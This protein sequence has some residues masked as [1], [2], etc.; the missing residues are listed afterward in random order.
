MKKENIPFTIAFLLLSNTL[1]AQLPEI[2][3]KPIAEIFTDF[4][5]NLNDTSKTTGFGLN[6]AYFGYNFIPSSDF[7]ATIILNI[8]NPEDLPISSV[9]RRYAYVR[10]ASVAYSGDRL[11]ISFGITGTRHFNY[12]QKFWGKRYIANTFQALNLF[13]VVADL[14][15]VAD[16]K[17]S[18]LISA[19]VTVMN[20]EGYSELQLDNG[21][22][23]SA[24]LTVTPSTKVAIR[25]YNDI[26]R[27]NGVWQYTL[28]TFAGFRNDHITIGAEFNYKTNLDLRAGDNAWGI[29][30][31]G[32]YSLPKKYEIFGRYDYS[33]SVALPED[34][35]HWNYLLDGNL[36]I[37]GI[38]RV[39]NQYFKMAISYQE[40]IPYDADL[41]SKSIIYLS[42]SF[43]F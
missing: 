36:V 23:T 41:N 12:Q 38:Q 26:N 1:L 31:T 9:H 6:R 10:E 11:H 35:N 25:F 18:D 39:F 21:V 40:T 5:I 2:K 19:D 28:L 13:G 7:S 8:G 27:Q 16:Y 33:A 3:G 30:A 20:G 37:G 4:H 17:F 24:G 34:T 29:S 32:A 14:G 42:A 15:V 22:K 43:K